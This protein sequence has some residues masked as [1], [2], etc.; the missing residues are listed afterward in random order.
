MYLSFEV[1]T[2]K[3]KSSRWI[4]MTYENKKARAVELA[5]SL[6]NQCVILYNNLRNVVKVGQMCRLHDNFL[7]ILQMLNSLG[8]QWDVMPS[9]IYH[10]SFAYYPLLIDMC[11]DEA[12]NIIYDMFKVTERIKF[13]LRWTQDVPLLNPSSRLLFALSTYLCAVTAMNPEFFEKHCKPMNMW[14]IN[15]RHH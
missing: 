11:K 13:S 4:E 3:V 8:S 5:E 15:D 7:F 14:K 2:S 9:T 1:N 12:L 6:M 10:A